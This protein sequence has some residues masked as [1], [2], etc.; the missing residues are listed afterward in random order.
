M[1]LCSR[2]I[3][4]TAG[5]RAPREERHHSTQVPGGSS[6]LFKIEMHHV[7]GETKPTT[8]CAPETETNCTDK[9]IAYVEKMRGRNAAGG[10][11]PGELERLLAL[12]DNGHFTEVDLD[13]LHIRQTLLKKMISAEATRSEL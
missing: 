9:E 12:E 8:K 6:I 1:D 4:E 11:L 7:Y 2:A 10:F 5:A 3:R 13:W